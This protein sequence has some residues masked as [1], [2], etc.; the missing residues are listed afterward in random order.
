MTT[1]PDLDFETIDDW[2]DADNDS[3]HLFVK[4][5]TTGKYGWHWVYRD[6][7]A[8]HGLRELASTGLDPADRY[9]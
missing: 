4:D 8:D 7:L 3:L 1:K 9:D 5:R 6:R 2:D